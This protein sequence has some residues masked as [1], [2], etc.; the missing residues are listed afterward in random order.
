[1]K[2]KMLNKKR[3][4]Q[5]ATITTLSAATLLLANCGG[6]GG[7]SNDD[8][9]T[10]TQTSKTDVVKNYADIAFA[11]FSDSSTTAIAL[12]DAIDVFVG[13]PT[14]ANLTLAKQAWLAAR[15]PYGQVEAYRFGNSNVDDW[16]GR[17]N[18]WPLDEGLID[19]VDTSYSSTIGNAFGLENVIADIGT[20]PTIDATLLRDTLHEAASEEANV[21]TG[22]HSIEF[23]LWGQ[24]LNASPG[25]SGQRRATDFNTNACTNGNCDRRSTYLQVAADVLVADLQEMVDDWDE[26]QTGNYREALLAEDADVGLRRMLRGMG[27]MSL[28]ELASERMLVGLAAHDQEEEHSCFSDNTHV[29]VVE[30]ARGVRNVYTGQ[31]TRIDGSV[32]S[33][34]SLSDLVAESDV[35]LDTNLNNA[36]DASM[37]AVNAIADKVTDATAPEKYDQQIGAGNTEGNARVK[38]AVDALVAQTPFIEQAAAA[39]GITGLGIDPGSC[40]NP[41]G[42]DNGS[43]NL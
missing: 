26:S 8:P 33:G 7:S 10:D 11:A 35:D 9:A 27:E 32:V 3:F 25:D 14:E 4:L 13:T 18:S 19:Y 1:M 34:P 39:L 40:F 41:D 2:F 23:L 43:C 15:V 30:N 38:A 22:Y 28:G 31:Y 16:E 6:G 24:D 5:F 17:T 29:D 20:Y 37:D 42:S 21:A 36:L 12:H